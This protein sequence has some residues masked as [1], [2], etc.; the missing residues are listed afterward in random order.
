MKFCINTAVLSGVLNNIVKVIPA[1]P[2]AASL[3]YILFR[4]EG[5]E[6]ITAQTTNTELSF[7]ASLNA[8]V[9][10]EGAFGVAAAN[11]V[12]LL[13]NISDET[14][15]LAVKDGKLVVSWSTGRTTFP[16][17]DEKDCAQVTRASEGASTFSVDAADFTPALAAVIPFTANDEIRPNL[18]C[19]YFDQTDGHLS[20]VATDSKSMVISPVPFSSGSFTEGFLIRNTQLAAAKGVL[21]KKGTV[22]FRFSPLKAEMQADNITAVFTLTAA[23]FPNYK[24]IIPKES[25]TPLVVARDAFLGS[26]KRVLVTAQEAHVKVVLSP[27]KVTLSSQDLGFGVLSSDNVVADYKG[28]D[29]TLGFKGGT[30]LSAVSAI[31]GNDARLS[32]VDPRRAVLVTS[33]KD[34]DSHPVVVLMPIAV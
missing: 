21:P 5:K 12:A 32:F 2:S 18:C 8:S 30:L 27:D 34:I 20:L 22:T 33:D 13:S 6:T 26:I 23:K 7:I 16:V 15:T 19:V 9:Q 11:F 31:A 10:E 4:S 3:G 1:K 14:V 24:A 28:D 29:L 25:T 17:Y